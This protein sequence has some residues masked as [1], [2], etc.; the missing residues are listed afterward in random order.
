MQTFLIFITLAASLSACTPIAAAA[1]ETITPAVT[2]TSIPTPTATPE[3]G[4]AVVNGE[5]V[6]LADAQAELERLKSAV[7]ETG[8]A[9]DEAGLRKQ[10]VEEL[11]GQTLLAQEALK[12]GFEMSDAQ[13][14][15]RIA[16]LAAKAGGEQAFQDWLN[17]NHYTVES[18]G[19]ALKR[20]VAAAWQAEKIAAT[21]PAEAEQVN[22]LQIFVRTQEDADRALE[23]A[24]QSGTEFAS[25]A[26]RYDPLAGGAL[27]WFPRGYLLRSEVEEAAFGLQPGEIS[28]IVTSEIGYHILYVVDRAAARPLDPQ[29][30][31]VIEQKT[32]QEWI[33]KQRAEAAVE[34]LL[35]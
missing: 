26:K 15:E 20:S 34:I 25:L 17:R 16:A 27:G 5:T 6:L 24:R 13:L 9:P 29:A 22:V 31:Q 7:E 1:T 19:R 28:G 21:V 35:P 8:A 18:F 30:R 11:I 12:N 10:A 33:E 14:E 2:A 23:R 32:L 4:A 3:P